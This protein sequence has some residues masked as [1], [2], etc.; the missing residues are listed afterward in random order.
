MIITNE[1]KVRVKTLIMGGGG[2][3]YQTF[4]KKILSNTAFSIDNKTDNN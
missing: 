3:M 2:G 4:H 1:N